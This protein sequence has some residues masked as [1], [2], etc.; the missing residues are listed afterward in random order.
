MWTW[1]PRATQA[2]TPF[3]RVLC[4]GYSLL[5][6]RQTTSCAEWLRQ[7][8]GITK[9]R[10]LSG[11]ATFSGSPGDNSGHRD[12]EVLAEIAARV[13]GDRVGHFADQIAHVL[14]REFGFAHA[15][16][17]DREHGTRGG[18]VHDAAAFAGDADDP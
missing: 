18:E 3:C 7:L 13:A 8:I 2:L 16:Q 10:V 9:E 4:T 6:S 5:Y 11:V 14:L 1:Y 12:H 17:H 15:H